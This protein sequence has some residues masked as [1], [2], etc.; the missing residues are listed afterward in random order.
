MASTKHTTFEAGD[1]KTGSSLEDLQLPMFHVQR[2]ARLFDIPTLEHGGKQEPTDLWPFH[3]FSALGDDLKMI[4]NLQLHMLHWR[5]GAT[6][7]RA[8]YDMLPA[9]VDKCKEHLNVVLEALVVLQKMKEPLGLTKLTVVDK[10]PY[11]IRGWGCTTGRLRT[12]AN[13]KAMFLN[14]YWPL[15]TQAAATLGISIENVKVDYKT[16]RGAIVE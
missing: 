5:L 12:M 7:P 1:A 2:T 3:R 15:L 14:A 13:I 4:K 16:F 10:V 11:R 8:F 6:Q 9:Y